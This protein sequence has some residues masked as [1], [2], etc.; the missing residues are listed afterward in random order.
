VSNKWPSGMRI[1]P[2]V[3]IKDKDWF[4]KLIPV[5][6]G[7]VMWTMAGPKSLPKAP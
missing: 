6:T 4:T 3:K 5:I 2:A 7:P 1:R